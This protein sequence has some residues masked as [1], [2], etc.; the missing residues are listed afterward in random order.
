MPLDIETSVLAQ[1]GMYAQADLWPLCAELVLAHLQ[2]LLSTHLTI[3]AHSKICPFVTW[4]GWVMK[5]NYTWMKKQHYIIW[6]VYYMYIGVCVCIYIFGGVYSR[7]PSRY[8]LNV[9]FN[10]NNSECLLHENYA[11]EGET[12]FALLHALI[13]IEDNSL[14]WSYWSYVY[15]QAKNNQRVLHVLHISSWL[16]QVLW[17]VS[18]STLFI[19]KLIITGSIFHCWFSFFSFHMH[20]HLEMTSYSLTLAGIWCTDY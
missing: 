2:I 9:L 3:Q 14:Y 5:S 6:S 20:V 12:C 1:L 16:W 8:M 13:K 18:F 17:A 19:S 7:Y 15:F 4:R 11:M 10:C